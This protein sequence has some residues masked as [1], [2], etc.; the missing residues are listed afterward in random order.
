MFLPA[1]SAGPGLSQAAS[2]A[3][4]NSETPINLK[5]SATFILLPF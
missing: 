2:P 5:L 4:N 3:T 1:V